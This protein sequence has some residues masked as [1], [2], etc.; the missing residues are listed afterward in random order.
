MTIKR[1]TLEYHSIQIQ[2]YTEKC[3]YIINNFSIFLW[4]RDLI[5]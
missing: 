3:L 2:K 5:L 1:E 4:I